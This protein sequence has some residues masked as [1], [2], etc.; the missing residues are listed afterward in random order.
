M[1]WDGVGWMD[2]ISKVY[3]KF[4]YTLWVKWT[5]I[6]LLLY[7]FKNCH[8]IC[9]GFENLMSSWGVW[10]WFSKL[11][12]LNVFLKNHA[13]SKVFQ[14]NKR[15]RTF[16]VKIWCQVGEMGYDLHWRPKAFLNLR[17][18]LPP[19]THRPPNHP[20]TPPNPQTPFPTKLLLK[21]HIT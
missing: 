7:M 15:P 12:W 4:L 9:Y 20:H 14:I 2:G 11:L 21:I 10:I 6:V 19:N 17:G 1:G 18:G 8:Q 3:F 16:F 5:F 13:K